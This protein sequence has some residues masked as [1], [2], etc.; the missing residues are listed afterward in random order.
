[1]QRQLFGKLGTETPA[2]MRRPL[3]THPEEPP[4]TW[5]APMKTTVQ[6]SGGGREGLT[7]P[8]AVGL[9][10]AEIT[11]FAKGAPPPCPSGI[12]AIGRVAREPPFAVATQSGGTSPISSH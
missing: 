11:V 2:L 10:L 4:I 5:V 12:V 3:D 8:K 6:P 1:M 7:C 9:L